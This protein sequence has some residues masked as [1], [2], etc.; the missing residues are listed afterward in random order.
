MSNYSIGA[1]VR[2]GPWSLTI[3]TPTRG[4]VVSSPFEQ[5]Y[6]RQ[7]SEARA[8]D[9]VA[10]RGPC[11]FDV[12]S[13][14]RGDNHHPIESFGFGDPHR[15]DFD[16][17]T[18]SSAYVVLAVVQHRSPTGT[19][20]RTTIDGLDAFDVASRSQS[21]IPHADRHVAIVN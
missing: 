1:V 2:V 6:P 3:T 16:Q 9:V 14:C 12:W 21:R 18:I 8:L 10:Q 19:L 5:T 11:L 7:R 15:F 17:A 13:R 20:E 4:P